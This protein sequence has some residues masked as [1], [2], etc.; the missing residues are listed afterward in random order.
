MPGENAPAPP[1]IGLS[2]GIYLGSSR[3]AALDEI[4][5]YAMGGLPPDLSPEGFCQRVH[6]AYGPP[7]DVAARLGADRVL[8]YTTE[9]ILQFDPIHPPLERILEMLEQVAKEVAPALGWQ[10]ADH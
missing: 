5:K 7:E 2:R 10:P 6:I 1:R 3:Q 4:E 9:L 8:P